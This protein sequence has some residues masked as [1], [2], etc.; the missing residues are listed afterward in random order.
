MWDTAGQEKFRTLTTSNFRG[1]HG[2][3]I[4][5]DVTNRDSFEEVRQWMQE[6]ETFASQNVCR[7]LLGNKC[8]Q[9]S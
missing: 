9:M 2:I 4:V 1:A 7:V 6:I 8:D 5:Y 3:I